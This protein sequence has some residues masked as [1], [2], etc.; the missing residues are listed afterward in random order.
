MEIILF[1][2]LNSIWNWIQSQN[3]YTFF[4]IKTYEGCRKRLYFQ[5]E[6]TASEFTAVV[7]YDRHLATANKRG[8]QNKVATFLLRWYML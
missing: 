1:L 8:K 7:A 2:D 3:H 6:G 5:K 4:L